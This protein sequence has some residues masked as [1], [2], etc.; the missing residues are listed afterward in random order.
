MMRPIDSITTGELVD[1][2]LN[3][4]NPMI[5]IGTKL[6]GNKNDVDFW[7][8]NGNKEH[9]YGLCHQLALKIQKEEIRKLLSEESTN[10]G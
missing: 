6:E 10:E 9:C 3:R 4:C 7:G 2:L 1:E 8:V 5:F